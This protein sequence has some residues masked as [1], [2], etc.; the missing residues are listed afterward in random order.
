MTQL[1]GMAKHGL[2]A[3]E[4]PKAHSS[5]SIASRPEQLP[6]FQYG[7]SIWDHCH[8]AID[9][10]ALARELHCSVGLE[11]TDGRNWRVITVDAD[12]RRALEALEVYEGDVIPDPVMREQR[13]RNVLARRQVEQAKDVLRGVQLEHDIARERQTLRN[14]NELRETG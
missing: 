4:M 14:Y 12:T 6:L 8:A 10:L 9:V 3:P 2:T 11:T 1:T 5:D 7:P 13:L